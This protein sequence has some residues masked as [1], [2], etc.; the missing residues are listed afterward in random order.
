[1]AQLR[2]YLYKCFQNSSLSTHLST[3]LYQNFHSG[4]FK[5]LLGLLMIVHLCNLCEFSLCSNAQHMDNFILYF[6]VS[7]NLYWPPQF[8]LTATSCKPQSCCVKC[9][10]P[11]SSNTAKGGQFLLALL[12][13]ST[14]EEINYAKVTIYKF[15]TF[16]SKIMQ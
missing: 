7:Q 13:L 9:Q 1:M 14:S 11:S 12:D 15:I 10:I 6:L 4:L 16:L 8:P 3:P 2:V 5:G